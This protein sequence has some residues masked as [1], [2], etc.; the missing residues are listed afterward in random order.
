MT[1]KNNIELFTTNNIDFL[2]RPSNYNTNNYLNNS[3]NPISNINLLN[4]TNDLINFF[5]KSNINDTINNDYFNHYI[6]KPS[7]NTS[8]I[9]PI[10]LP[11]TEWPPQ[12]KNNLD[13]YDSDKVLT[14]IK[15]NNFNSS[16]NINDNTIKSTNEFTSQIVQPYIDWDKHEKPELYYNNLIKEGKTEIMNEYIVNIDSIDRDINRYPNPFN[17]KVYFK[18]IPNQTGAVIN[19][20]FKN[21]K[22]LDLQSMILPRKFYIN[23]DILD[24][25]TIDN[26]INSLFNPNTKSGDL[27]I[28]SDKEYLVIDYYN[29]D[30]KT[31]VYM[32]KPNNNFISINECWEISKNSSN[33]I[34]YH[35]FFLDNYSLEQEKFLLLYI[36]EI[37]DNKKLSSNYNIEKAFSI[38]YPDYT[39]SEYYYLDTRFVEKTYK[40]SELGNIDNLTIKICNSQGVQLN[41]NQSALDNNIKTLNSCYCIDILT[42]TYNKKYNCCCCYF[43]HPYFLKN[44][45]NLL[46]KIGVV[47][48]DIDKRVFN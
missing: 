23:K 21:V 39:N 36:D 15:S 41:I 17:Y 43:R 25:N 27:F 46:F 28:L 42:K 32:L 20:N 14:D 10:K 16:S 3:F 37:T 48:T 31:L 35:H 5:K 22:Y 30:I 2:N 40:F 29:N 4:E 19:R 8:S 7:N 34:Y 38:L 33:F 44:Q 47:E 26:N 45:N 11:L 9:N 1:D 6:S 18:S 13:L 24:I 12:D